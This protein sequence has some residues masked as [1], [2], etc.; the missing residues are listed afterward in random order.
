MRTEE[1]TASHIVKFG[2]SEYCSLINDGSYFSFLVN[3]LNGD[4]LKAALEEKKKE[5]RMNISTELRIRCPFNKRCETCY[6]NEDY[7]V[8]KSIKNKDSKEIDE[9]KTLDLMLIGPGT[10]GLLLVKEL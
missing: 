9:S 5:M 8:R 6:I 1:K 10:Y 7:K 4:E 3:T 2:G